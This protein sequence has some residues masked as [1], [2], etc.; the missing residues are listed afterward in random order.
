VFLILVMHDANMKIYL[1]KFSCNMKGDT[2]SCFVLQ[3]TAASVKMEPCSDYE[4]HSLSSLGEDEGEH[5]MPVFI[6]VMKCEMKA[7]YVLMSC[8]FCKRIYRQ[9]LQKCVSF[10]CAKAVRTNYKHNECDFLCTSVNNQLDT[11]FSM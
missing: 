9:S 3:C 6:P 10:T 2:S 7:S 11:L 4:I 5:L 1:Y 8:P